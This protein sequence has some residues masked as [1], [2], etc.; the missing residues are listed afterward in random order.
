M[1]Q[2]DIIT[3]ELEVHELN[4]LAVEILFCFVIYLE[5]DLNRAIKISLKFI[6]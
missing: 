6:S 4:V 5:N 3:H 1:G 2:F